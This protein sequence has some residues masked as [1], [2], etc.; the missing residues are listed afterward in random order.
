MTHIPGEPCACETSCWICLL[1]ET[2][3]P[4][5]DHKTTSEE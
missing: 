1:D 3:A 2:P 4:T 5:A